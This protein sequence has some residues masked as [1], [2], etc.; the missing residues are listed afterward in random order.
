MKSKLAGGF[1][2]LQSHLAMI[3]SPW[4]P[5]HRQMS[6]GR[7]HFHYNCIDMDLYSSRYDI[8]SQIACEGVNGV[9]IRIAII[10]QHWKMYQLSRKLWFSPALIVL[11]L[12]VL[13]TG[14][15]DPPAEPSHNALGQRGSERAAGRSLQ[16][17]VRLCRRAQ[18]LQEMIGVTLC[19]SSSS[20]SSFW[21]SR[22][23]FLRGQTSLFLNLSSL[24]Q[25]FSY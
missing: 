14:S 21:T 23:L 6:H 24:I 19:S 8:Q 12:L 5:D 1:S 16:V 25:P 10:I 22:P 9:Q 20:S 3:C 13:P 17:E 4:Q 18:P 7:S 15:D 11:L 2:W